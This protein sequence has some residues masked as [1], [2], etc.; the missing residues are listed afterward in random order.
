MTKKVIMQ[1]KEMYVHI[2]FLDL[3]IVRVMN[4]VNGLLTEK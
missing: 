2:S 4:Y 3:F 1:G